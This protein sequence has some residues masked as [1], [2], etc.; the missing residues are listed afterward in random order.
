MIKQESLNSRKEDIG[1]L[2]E[3]KLSF[4]T[5]S[6]VW[7]N[8]GWSIY[9]TIHLTTSL[10]Q[11][12]IRQSPAEA[13]LRVCPAGY[14]AYHTA[15]SLSSGFRGINAHTPKFMK[16][17]SL[18]FCRV[19]PNRSPICLCVSPWSLSSIISLSYS[20][21]CR[22]SL[23]IKIPPMIFLLYHRRVFFSIVR[24]LRTCSLYFAGGSLF[25]AA[26]GSPLHV[27][28]HFL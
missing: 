6:G 17:Q 15:Y 14:P 28:K 26:A 24:F 18:I 25:S 11:R 7:I 21:I 27:K 16:S 22:Y 20:L 8:H 1:R 3:E 5:K 4:F 19:K 13:S 12:D 23:D 9:S 2:W 10:W